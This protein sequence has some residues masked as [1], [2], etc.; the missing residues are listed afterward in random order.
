IRGCC[1]AFFTAVDFFRNAYFHI[2]L[3]IRPV[4][5]GAI[6]KSQLIQSV[7]SDIVTCGPTGARFEVG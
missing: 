6:S 5:T 4:W 1:D 2:Y 7:H 3:H